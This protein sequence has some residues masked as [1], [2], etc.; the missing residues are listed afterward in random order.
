MPSFS[1]E[2]LH[3]AL[4]TA[5]L[6]TILL[7][8]AAIR[9]WLRRRRIV[10]RV[11]RARQGESRA[12]DLLEA[13]GYS[14]VAT[15]FGGSYRLLIDDEHLAIPLRADYLVTREGLR[16]V[17]EVKTGNYAPHLRTPATRR[18]LLE[19][20][21]AF[22]VDGV[23]LVDAEQERVHVVCFPLGARDSARHFSWLGWI[24]VAIGAA[25]LIA[26]QWR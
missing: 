13:R 21:I 7:G 6:V 16:Y 25:A 4:F 1:L 24:A 14:V 8:H 10:R 26:A 9:T 17:A 5:G 19:Y 2:H 18:Q 12:R 22:D 15:Q 11:V 23:L 20:R 3:L